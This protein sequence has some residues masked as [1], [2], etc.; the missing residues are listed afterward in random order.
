MFKI[1]GFCKIEKTVVNFGILTKSKDDFNPYCKE[2]L[3]NK[4]KEK[5]RR[6]KK[7]SPKLVYKK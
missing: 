4:R 6:N 2:C 7:I 3:K 5:K 1:C